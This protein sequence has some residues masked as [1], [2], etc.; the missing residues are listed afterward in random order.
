MTEHP[1]HDRTRAVAE[2]HHYRPAAGLHALLPSFEL[3]SHLFGTP[4]MH[5]RLITQADLRDDHRVLEIGCGT[6]NLTIKA[7]RAYPGAD[8]IGSD[9]DP[10]ALARAQRKAKEL[11]GIRFESGYSQELPY[12]DGEFDRVLSALMLH[13]LDHD[14]KAATAA[15]A[16]RVLRPGGRLH[17]LDVGGALTEGDGFAPQRKLLERMLPDNIGDTIPRLLRSAGFT[18]A[19]VASQP[20]RFVGRVTYYRATRP[21]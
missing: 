3:I 13:H 19:E 11:T 1:P 10:R 20:H 15:E 6:G 14:V 2:R 18:C 21:H 12:G 9:P 5:D 8:I 16:W 7:K 17:I 4:K